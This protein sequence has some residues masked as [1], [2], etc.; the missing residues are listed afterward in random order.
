MHPL[1]HGR[2]NGVAKGSILSSIRA[3]VSSEDRHSISGD[4]YSGEVDE[5]GKP[6][7]K[8]TLTFDEGG[9]YAGEFKHGKAHGQGTTHY[10]EFF[11][12]VGEH[13]DGRGHGLGVYENHST[14]ETYEGFVVNDMKHGR[15]KLVKSDGTVIEGT[16]EDNE[17][18]E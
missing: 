3:P 11:T 6:H 13:R 8:G 12:Y 14:G 4:R 7:G 5:D 9:Y 10:P 16:W 1:S 17:L 2:V 15:G 18:V